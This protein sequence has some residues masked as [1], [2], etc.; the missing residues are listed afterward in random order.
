MVLWAYL[1]NRHLPAAPARLLMRW[2]TIRARHRLSAA[3]IP[4]QRPM[5]PVSPIGSRTFPP[6]AGHRW[7]SWK[8]RSCRASTRSRKRNKS[9]SS[10]MRGVV[11]AVAAAQHVR[12][13]RFVLLDQ[14]TY[15]V[16]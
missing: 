15:L 13:V 16:H 12:E 9:R 11:D 4:F 3:A 6:A 8:G 10:D 14:R 7:N 1:R 2:L 5:T